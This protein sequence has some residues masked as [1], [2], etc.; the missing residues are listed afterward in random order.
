LRQYKWKSV[1]VGVFQSEWVTLTANFRRKG[2]RSP[3]TTVGVKKT[4]VIALACG[5]KIFAVHCLI[6]SQS[7]SMTDEHNY[8]SH[9]KLAASRGKN[10]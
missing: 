8:D 10:G 9:K 3:P 4:R 6:L 1:E 2:R 5:I 7:T